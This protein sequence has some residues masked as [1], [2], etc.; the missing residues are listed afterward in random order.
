[1]ET[2]GSPEEGNT[3]QLAPWEKLVKK[4][5]NQMTQRDRA[6]A[7]QSSASELGKESGE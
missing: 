2:P 4:H 6:N 7:K 5:A 1:M 3:S